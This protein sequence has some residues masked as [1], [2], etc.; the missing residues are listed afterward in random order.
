MR[1]DHIIVSNR[2]L[3][4]RRRNWHKTVFT[5]NNGSLIFRMW[6]YCSFLIWYCVYCLHPCLLVMALL[7]PCMCACVKSSEGNIILYSTFHTKRQFK[8]FHTRIQQASDNCFINLIN[9]QVIQLNQIKRTTTDSINSE[10]SLCVWNQQH[11]HQ[12]LHTI[13]IKVLYKTPF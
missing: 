7:H 6:G 11:Q 2:D 5:L 9:N 1:R 4:S 13:P 12:K 3:L 8:V 10:P